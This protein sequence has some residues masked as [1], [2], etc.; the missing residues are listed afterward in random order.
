VRPYSLTQNSVALL[1]GEDTRAHSRAAFPA[2]GEFVL[3]D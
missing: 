2:D 3:P 1:H